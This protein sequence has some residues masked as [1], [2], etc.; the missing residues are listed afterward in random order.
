MVS[1]TIRMK[2]SECC[3]SSKATMGNSRNYPYL[4]QLWLLGFP[5]ARWGSLSWNSKGIGGGG[6]FKAGIASMLGQT[7]VF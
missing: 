7:R 2:V 4:Y 1:V 3:F 5:K 6:G